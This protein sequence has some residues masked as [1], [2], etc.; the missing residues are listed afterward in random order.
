M[1]ISHVDIL[2]YLKADVVIAIL[3][4]F[5]AAGNFFWLF[6]MRNI[7]ANESVI[8]YWKEKAEFYENRLKD[9][10]KVIEE[11]MHKKNVY[12]NQ[13]L[14]LLVKY[15]EAKGALEAHKEHAS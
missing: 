1:S 4:F 8:R 11:L 10:Q 5:A 9:N 12:K 3:N 13:Y 15:K 7:Q 6:K 2:D 14:N